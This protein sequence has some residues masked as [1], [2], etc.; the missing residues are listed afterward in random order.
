MLA[1]NEVLSSVGDFISRQVAE[2]IVINSVCVVGPT[3]QRY[4]L[5]RRVATA[6]TQ[7]TIRGILRHGKLK[8]AISTI[9]QCSQSTSPA[10]HL[11][12]MLRALATTATPF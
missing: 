10:C 2:V 11:E 8:T 5:T 1:P 6:A 4:I 12:T 9:Q 3:Q 7:I